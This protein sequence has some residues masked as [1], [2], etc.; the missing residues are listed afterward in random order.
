MKMILIL[1][2]L[3]N[4]K[5]SNLY[6][7]VL[8]NSKVGQLAKKGNQDD[9]GCIIISNAVFNFYT[10]ELST[11]VLPITMLQFYIILY[12]VSDTESPTCPESHKYAYDYGAY[13]CMHMFDGANN[14]IKLGSES[15]Q[16]IDWNKD[17]KEC[18]GR[19]SGKRCVNH[20]SGK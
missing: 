6:Q 10:I 14:Y 1:M 13:C 8:E 2:I 20:P 17:S 16:N 15:C 11:I 7:K 4:V 12:Y 9:Q 19:K 18:P 5:Q 3:G